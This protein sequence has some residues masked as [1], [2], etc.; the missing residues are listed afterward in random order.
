[1]GE[2]IAIA[3]VVEFIFGLCVIVPEFTIKMANLSIEHENWNDTK[4]WNTLSLGCET[5]NARICLSGSTD[6]P[7]LNHQFLF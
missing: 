5:K 1:M 3:N 4:G 7:A 6:S 2:F